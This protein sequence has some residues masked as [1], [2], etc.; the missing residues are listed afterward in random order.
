MKA[1]E[2]SDYVDRLGISNIQFAKVMGVTE[3]TVRNWRALGV[4][5]LGKLALDNPLLQQKI[6]NFAAAVEVVRTGTGE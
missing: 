4:S 5:N 3:P 1:Q 2:F 6:K